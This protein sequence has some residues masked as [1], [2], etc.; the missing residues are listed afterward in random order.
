MYVELLRVRRTFHSINRKPHHRLQSAS[1]SAQRISSQLIQVGG[2]LSRRQADEIL[3]GGS[4]SSSL[5]Y[6]KIWLCTI[7]SLRR[8]QYCSILL[9]LCLHICTY[10]GICISTY[11]YVCTYKCLSSLQYHRRDPYIHNK[12]FDKIEI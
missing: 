6:T 7:D 4:V 11:T 2:V 10:I 5:V 12:F 9:E 1:T 3:L 8:I